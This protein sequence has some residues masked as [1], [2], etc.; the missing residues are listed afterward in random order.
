MVLDYIYTSEI[1][2]SGCYNSINE[3]ITA[4]KRL[5]I[6]SLYEACDLLEEA[7]LREKDLSGTCV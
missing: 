5:K 4:T 3:V 1:V 2:L 7:I 6:H